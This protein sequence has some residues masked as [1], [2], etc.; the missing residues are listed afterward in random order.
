MWAHVIA[1]RRAF[2]ALFVTYFEFL[3]YKEFLDGIHKKVNAHNLVATRKPR[4][5][6][7]R[8]IIISGHI[9]DLLMNGAISSIFGGKGFG[10]SDVRAQSA[11]HCSP[12]LLRFLT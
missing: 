9:V 8:R 11:L 3:V 7:K 2:A 6:V 4:G 5:E 10:P 12:L 1:E